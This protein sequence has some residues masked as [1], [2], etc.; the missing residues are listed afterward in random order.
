MARKQ[1][2][3]DQAGAVWREELS[4]KLGLV[5]LQ[6]QIQ[7]A[8]SKLS[9]NARTHWNKNKDRIAEITAAG[10]NPVEFIKQQA[11]FLPSV[12]QELMPV[13]QLTRQAV[14]CGQSVFGLAGYGKIPKD[15]EGILGRELMARAVGCGTEVRMYVEEIKEKKKVSE[16][17]AF[18]RATT[19]ENIKMFALFGSKPYDG[20]NLERR[21]EDGLTTSSEEREQR[22]QKAF[23]FTSNN[24][25]AA[26]ISAGV[27]GAAASVLGLVFTPSKPGFTHSDL[28][29][30]Q[31]TQFIQPI[32]MQMAETMRNMT[33]N[34]LTK[35]LEELR[36]KYADTLENYVSDPEDRKKLVASAESE[37]IKAIKEEKKAG[38]KNAV[39][40]ALT[41]IIA[42]VA[43]N[44]DNA[45]T[46][47]ST[48]ALATPRLTV[49]IGHGPRDAGH[50]VGVGLSRSG[51]FG[52]VS[53]S[54]VDGITKGYVRNIVGLAAIA[55]QQAAANP[56]N[57]DFRT[58]WKGTGGRGQASEIRVELP[59]VIAELGPGAKAKSSITIEYGGKLA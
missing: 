54:N 20:Q 15:A 28:Q 48:I 17:E 45:L 38:G 14:I 57:K 55:C 32:L 16:D 46:G 41:G 51:R 43:R 59:A 47:H 31:L 58:F 44:S 27:I 6:P 4:V 3:A 49:E 33:G 10:K 36:R 56:Q 19:P 25:L 11:F 9:P 7:A 5:S 26:G 37:L 35:A 40:D 22:R 12:K 50:G 18:K 42:N 8:E 30:A 2:E 13:A 21:K 52:R 39:G 24:A 23:D 34:T 1:N 53:S 29:Q